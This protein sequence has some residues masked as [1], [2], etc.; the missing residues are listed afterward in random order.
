MDSQANIILEQY[1]LAI[2]LTI[3][4]ILVDGDGLYRASLSASSI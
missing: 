4:E 3:A 1:Q 2:S